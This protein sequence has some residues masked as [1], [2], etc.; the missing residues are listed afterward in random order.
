MRNYVLS[1]VVVAFI[2]V[3]LVLFFRDHR[4]DSG[5]K[6]SQSQYSLSPDAIERLR[7]EAVRGDCESSIR[8][9]KYY[10]YGGLDLDVATKWLRVATKCPGVAPKEYLAR[11][12]MRNSGDPAAAV[13]V[14][15]LIGE[16][17]KTDQAKAKELEDQFNELFRPPQ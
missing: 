6:D 14:R 11:I 10:L 8:L 2:C 3:G 15:R 5:W 9:A 17:R 7:R 1:F 13:E 4:P 12:L 16:I